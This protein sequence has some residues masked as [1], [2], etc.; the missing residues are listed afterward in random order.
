MERGKDT[1]IKNSSEAFKDDVCSLAG[2][3]SEKG[4]GFSEKGDSDFN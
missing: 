1:F 3:I 4:T 2:Y